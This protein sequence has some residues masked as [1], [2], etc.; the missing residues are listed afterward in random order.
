VGSTPAPGARSPQRSER[1]RALLLGLLLAAGPPPAAAAGAPECVVVLHGLARSAAS[2][3]KL[4][5]AVR[6]AGF[7]ARNID[8][9]S[10]KARVQ[11]LSRETLPR[12]YRNNLSTGG[13]AGDPFTDV[14]ATA[15][16]DLGGGVAFGYEAEYTDMDGDGDFDVWMNNFVRNAEVVI[17]NE[18]GL[19]FEIVNWVRGDPASLDGEEDFLD[20]DGDGDLDVAMSSVL[21]ENW[22]FQAGQTQGLSETEGYF[23]RTGTST[24]GSLAPWDETPTT[25]NGDYT[26]DV[27]AGDMDGD[28][29]PDLL[30]VNSFATANR[31]WENVLGVPDT[32]APTFHQVT[33]QSDKSDG[34]DTVIHA[35]VRDNAAFY[36]VG[37]N[38]T[39]LVYTVDG[40]REA[41]LRMDH[42]GGQQ[43]RAVIPG[44]IDGR[45]AYRVESTDDAGNTGVSAT[46]VYDQTSSGVVLWEHVDCGTP[47]VYGRPYFDA[48]GP[49]TGNS[50]LTFNL[51]DAAPD[52][53]CTL[54]LSAF[55]TPVPFKGGLLYPIPNPALV[56]LVTDAGGQLWF[57]LVWPPGLPAGVKL[58]WQ[59]TIADDAALGNVSV[60][61]A[62][63]STTP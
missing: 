40:G 48:S 6:Q 26:L 50:V 55:S 24:A 47:G 38:D 62:M 7:E 54:W 31:Y 14:T 41:C 52:A 37:F 13:W 35:Q 8:Y 57:P 17:R 29:D 28:G 39:R 32:H 30:M 59:Y 25:G 56:N 42:Q 2:M 49:L 5:E 27:E 10:R 45:V 43:F 21:G 53:P 4:A 33:V 1:G 46:T 63:V 61:N 12:I 36:D 16:P 58:W 44:G 34:T 18:G 20:Y 3:A 51:W 60:S 23:H 9:P 22:L 19:D 11:A 15:L